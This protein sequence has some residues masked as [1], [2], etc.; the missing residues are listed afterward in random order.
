MPSDRSVFYGGL[1]LG[2]MFGF[3]FVLTAAQAAL[4]LKYWIDSRS[5]YRTERLMLQYYDTL[6]DKEASNM[7]ADS[8][9]SR[10]ESP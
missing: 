4:S 3:M 6:K 1:A 8:T 7:T 9:A 10:R 5:G 2:G